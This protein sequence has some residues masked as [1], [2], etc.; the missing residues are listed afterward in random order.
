MSTSMRLLMLLTGIFFLLYFS[1]E[2]YMDMFER[3]AIAIPEDIIFV[4]NSGCFLSARQSP[5]RYSPAGEPI[6][7][8]RCR[9]PQLM[10]ARTRKGANFL[11]PKAMLENL[12]CTYWVLAA[13]DF[14]SN[15]VLLEGHFSLK[16]GANA[17][18]PIGEGQQIV[19][20]K[21]KNQTNDTIYHDV[22]FFLP[23]PLRKLK[24]N[25]TEKLSV[26]V[27]GIDSI[28]QMHFV[29]SFPQLNG[30]LENVHTKFFGYSRVGQDARANLM[31]FLSG[32]SS[33]EA[34][35]QT[36]AWLW[37]RFRAQ[38][39]GTAY[40]EDS[41]EVLFTTRNEKKQ[42][43]SEPTEF[44]LPPVLLEMHSHSRYSLDLREMIYCTAGRQFQEVLRDFI[45]K[46]VPH[47]R[48]RPFFSF[49]WESQGVQEYYEFATQLDQPYMMLLK[50]LQEA[51]ILNNT[52]LF[53]MSDH[54]LRAGDYRSS[55]QG[56]EE[57][58]QPLLLAIYPDWLKVKYPQAM[59]NFE[60]NSHSLVTPYDL[61]Q[62]LRDITCLD[63]LQNS[64]IEQRNKTLQSHLPENLPR[65]ISLFLPIPE[66]R[67][68]ELAHI[69]SLFCFC[70]KHTEIP[71]DDGLVLR[72]SRF[73]VKSINQ[74]TKPHSQCA[75][76][77][78]HSVVMAYFMDFGE[79]SFD[80]ELRLRVMTLPGHGEFEATVRVSDAL[81][82]TSS[83]SR[84]NPYQA[85]SHCVSDPRIK[86]LCFCT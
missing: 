18:I 49:F 46:L 16:R 42:F 69:P 8:L 5:A 68:C 56:M 55:F 64:Q 31:P 62:T 79:E 76:L 24:P 15:K 10:S 22:H 52:I 14:Q 48:Q 45:A 40:G 50:S 54:G 4:N 1:L 83:I 81:K 82:L 84:V 20:V 19:R 71:L 23:P 32:F 80:H 65:G 11:V 27:L 86:V 58:S 67:T 53:L 66:Y 44:Y 85:Q 60:R 43:P 33:D 77:K 30:F 63:Q 34:E 36:E 26:M 29:R 25:E 9:K 61:H 72:C 73:L 21:C 78:L 13:K 12:Q 70:R 59:E 39:Y 35:S 3:P 6:N 17:D 74:L 38:G 57:E 41:A 47:M 7:L 28:S 75:E 51:D 2:P 37:E